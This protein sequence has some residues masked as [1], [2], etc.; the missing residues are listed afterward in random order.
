MTIPEFHDRVPCR[1]PSSRANSGSHNQTTA[2]SLAWSVTLS[3]FTGSDTVQYGLNIGTKRSVTS[4]VYLEDPLEKALG[5]LDEQLKEVLPAKDDAEQQDAFEI[6]S[7]LE[8]R[9]S[10]LHSE[11]SQICKLSGLLITC[12]LDPDLVAV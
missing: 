12:T 8:I 9:D 5:A 7:L 10:S 6:P 3:L 2:L 4:R 1:A 11:V